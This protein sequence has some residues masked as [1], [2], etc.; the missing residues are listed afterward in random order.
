MIHF[1]LLFMKSVSKVCVKIHF[2]F[3]RVTASGEVRIG[4]SNKAET[5]SFCK[6][7]GFAYTTKRNLGNWG[8][9]LVKITQILLSGPISIPRF[10]FFHDNS[11]SHMKS[12]EAINSMDFVIW[13]LVDKI[14]S[15]VF[16]L[17]VSALWLIRNSFSSIVERIQIL[18]S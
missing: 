1:K 12:G 7:G 9:E 17:V 10:L 3:S 6:Q 5:A 2:F 8:V 13:R 18:K 11:L 16:S 4:S 14:L 15:L